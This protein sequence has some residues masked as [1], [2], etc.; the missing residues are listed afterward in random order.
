MLLNCVFAFAANIAYYKF[1][2]NAND[3][4]GA[5]PG[6]VHGNPVYVNGVNGQALD[7]DGIDDYMVVPKTGS[8]LD[9]TGNHV[10]VS[11]WVNGNWGSSTKHL[12]GIGESN[13][14][15]NW[16]AQY[17]FYYRT[18]PVM[19]FI[20]DT[21]SS[22][23]TLQTHTSFNSGEWIHV[24]GVYD[25]SNMYI[26]LNGKLE[27]TKALTGN[28][29][30][31]M[32]DF[33][34]GANALNG[35]L[36]LD[37]SVDELMVYDTAL[38]SAEIQ[39]LYNTQA[40]GLP[41]SDECSPAGS[42]CS[43]NTPY[44][45][46]LNASDGCLDRVDGTS[47]S[48]GSI[49]SAGTCIPDP[50]YGITKCSDYPDSVGC[51]NNICSI[52]YCSWN[53]NSASCENFISSGMITYHT[54]PGATDPSIIEQNDVFELALAGQTDY[55]TQNDFFDVDLS[56]TFV[57]PSG[58]STTVAGFYY[59]TLNGVPYWKARFAPD[60]T[61]TYSYSYLFEHIPSGNQFA[62]S[63]SFQVIPGSNPGFIRQNPNNPFR[64]EFANGEPFYPI[65]FNGFGGYNDQVGIDGGDRYGAFS[66]G[67]RSITRDER[68]RIFYDAGF[69]MVRFSQD[70]GGIP[71]LTVNH[72]Q[73]DQYN[74]SGGMYIDWYM[75]K[76]HGN[77]FRIMFGFFGFEN[78]MEDPPSAQ[79]LAF[80]RYAVDRYAAYVDAWEVLNERHAPGINSGQAWQTIIT[81][82]IK[83]RDPYNHPISTSWEL[84]TQ[85]VPNLL[86]VSP[87]RYSNEDEL[88][89]DYSINNW[90][91]YKGWGKP[92][93]LGEQG[94]ADI[95]W[96]PDSAL[97]MRIRDWTAFFKEVSVIF[98]D[99][100]YATNGMINPGGV[101]N[102]YL[103]P[104]ER[105]YNHIMMWFV[106]TVLK[107]DSA[108]TTVTVSNSNLMRAYGLSSSDGFAAYIHHYADHVNTVS[109][110]TI[111]INIPRAGQGYWIEPATGKLLGTTQ[112]TAG[113]NTLTIPD[114]VIDIAFFS[115]SSLGDT[116]PI[117]SVI[118]DNP[119]ADGDLDDDSQ[120][121]YGPFIMPFG[122]PP[123]TLN[124]DASNSYDLDGGAVTV[125][126]DF[127]DSTTG[128]GPVVSHTYQD[129]TYLT[130]LSVTDDEG[131]VAKHD[132]VVRASA[133]PNPVHNDAPIF[134][135]ASNNVIVKEG[136]PLI[137]TVNAGDRELNSSS[138]YE[139]GS[140][141]KGDFIYSASNLPQGSSFGTWGASWS[142][143]FFWIPDFNQAGSYQVQFDVQ[144]IQG[145]A[146]PTQTITI[147]VLDVPV[148]GQISKTCAG[149]Y[150][151]DCNNQVCT[152]ETVSALQDWNNGWITI[153]AMGSVL[154]S[155]KTSGC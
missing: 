64:W 20:V 131:N 124:F 111:T 98:W 22:H 42:F 31:N 75:N 23:N 41:C 35:G 120:L 50:C 12:V 147:H 148:A 149:P 94:N 154:N 125:S 44:T 68:L 48:A 37:G 87:H 6:T 17:H 126:W 59:Q 137:I 150:D 1:D 24:A 52:G 155:W 73:Y 146:A 145:A 38:S 141:D 63:G 116:K 56:V 18:G 136:E 102:I 129:G 112:V 57:S 4:T 99:T 85:Y 130:V 123:L 3:E 127:G 104:E 25:G 77:K 113:P 30:S 132:F 53:S 74:D 16:K 101:G 46:T 100:T 143:Q 97:R 151:L 89:S 96:L 122:M 70:N 139:G 82:E 93:I 81:N 76:L 19:E 33:S 80:I 61:G 108:I 21:A 153:T 45:C 134:Q 88:T 121:D 29:Y 118:I 135:L 90:A 5:N 34:V 15:E 71:S 72:D 103:G 58:K 8:N 65:G 32:V 106:K 49:C 54:S 133:D 7:F 138:Q 109:G 107:S 114:F 152:N 13:Q 110:Q 117:A 67:G 69:N 28:I 14:T 142:K 66:E 55:G 84:V 43:G 2:G 91:N 10:T 39:Q 95:N 47:C 140:T 51:S 92:V 105:Q 60:E 78:N 9:I 62:G 27:G 119:Q 36:P 86:I 128:S 83:A 40:A 79:R 144:D 11:F 115:T 26:Y